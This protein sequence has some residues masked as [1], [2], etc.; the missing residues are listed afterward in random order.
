VGSQVAEVAERLGVSRQSGHDSGSSLKDGG[1]AAL[2]DQSR[3]PH[4]HPV[5]LEAEAEVFICE[6]GRTHLR[7]PPDPPRVGPPGARCVAS[8]WTTPPGSAGWLHVLG[9]DGG[10]DGHG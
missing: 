9:A 1:I 8:R 5:Q 4:H 7:C 2:A 10:G 6:L 3:R